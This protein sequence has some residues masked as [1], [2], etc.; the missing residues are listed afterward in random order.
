M[1]SDLNTRLTRIKTQMRK[2][3]VGYLATRDPANILYLTGCRRHSPGDIIGLITPTGVTLFTDSRCEETVRRVARN[4]PL[5]QVFIWNRLRM[6][7]DF[8]SHIR[9]GST[10]GFE[11]KSGHTSYDF[12]DEMKRAGR[13]RG[14]GV[15]P[16]SDIIVG[17]RSIKTADEIA[18]LRRAGAI[19]DKA[20]RLT[21]QHVKPGVTEFEIGQRLDAYLRQLSGS[22][23]LAFETTVASG[24]NGAIP[25]AGVTDRKIRRGDMV[26]FDCGCVFKGY[27]ADTTRTVFIREVDPSM[28]VAYELVLK[29]L[30]DAERKARPGMTGQDIDHI[31]RDMIAAS[32]LGKW[33]FKHATG[34]GVGVDPH[35]LPYLSYTAPG[36]N[37]LEVGAVFSI[38]PAIYVDGR[39]GLRIEDTG[40]MTPTGF[41]SFNRFPKGVTIV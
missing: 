35:E 1:K 12:V 29:A 20:L 4:Q 41:K 23:E 37:P 33:V 11:R 13:R 9:H 17:V 6:W 24:P 22:S 34:H 16:V 2:A 19:S 15:K 7:D 30:T 40:V 18:L 21:L 27:R 39:F 38:E 26:T 36:A 31:A 14:I 3:G 32:E 28:L 5:V 10:L 25:H 8:A